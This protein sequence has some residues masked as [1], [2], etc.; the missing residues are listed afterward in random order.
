DTPSHEKQ[1]IARRPRCQ[2]FFCQPADTVV[3]V[4]ARQPVFFP[5]VY[6]IL[7]WLL[8]GCAAPDAT[9]LGR[10]AGS[11]ACAPCHAELVRTWEAS[12][13]H[14]AMLPAK[15]GAL[16]RAEPTGSGP[17]VRRGDDLALTAASLGHSTDVPAAYALGHEHVE[18]YVGA[19]VPD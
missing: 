16:L 19:L 9:P 3:T 2:V 15:P 7:A 5:M 18:Q 17:L 10:Y 12:P 8:G 13:H 14:L 6:P 4:R 11:S 1:V